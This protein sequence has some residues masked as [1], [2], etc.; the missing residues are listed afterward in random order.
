MYKKHALFILLFIF[1][2]FVFG[3]NK[4]ENIVSVNDGTSTAETAPPLLDIK[5]DDILTPQQIDDALGFSVENTVVAD[6]GTTV[7]YLSGDMLS[8]CEVGMMDCEREIYDSTISLYEDA[9]DTPNLGQ[10]AIW[11]NDAKQLVV[12]NGEYMISI[13]VAVNVDNN[14]ELLICSRQIA[15]LLLEKL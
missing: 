4:T 7:R 11:S 2:F 10:A 6:E 1:L 14:D 13:T 8:Y 12:Y 3:C 5:I 9:V 15:A